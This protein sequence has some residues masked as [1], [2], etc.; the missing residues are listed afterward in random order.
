[1]A[2][3]IG[4]GTEPKSFRFEKNAWLCEDAPAS[5][6]AVLKLP[7]EESGGVYGQPIPA[8]RPAQ[9]GGR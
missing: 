8:G 9:G 6:R 3:N 5:T 1:M 7:V 2:V 4:G